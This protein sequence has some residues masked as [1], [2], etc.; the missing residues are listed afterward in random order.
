MIDGRNVDRQGA[1]K[2]SKMRSWSA[3]TL[4]LSLT[5]PSTGQSYGQSPGPATGGAVVPAKTVSPGSGEQQPI[6]FKTSEVSLDIVVTDKK[7][8]PVRDIRTEELEIY[9]DGARQ[10][11]T[12]FR[13]ISDSPDSKGSDKNEAA[14][15]RSESSNAKPL[16]LVT[17]LF[18]HLSVQRV[19]PVRDAAFQ[20]IDNS[21][22][23]SMQVRVMTI[24]RKLYL[25]ENFTGDKKRLR[26]AVELATSTVEKSHEERS[27]ALA[28]QLRPAAQL[29][30]E[31]ESPRETIR[32]AGD[33][34][35]T[36]T[37]ARMSLDALEQSA[38]MAEEV[39][40][41]HHVFSLIPFA[42][43]H[44]QVPGRKMA[45][46]F[47]DGLYLPPGLAPAIRNAIHESTRGG[48]SFYSINIRDLL[49]GAGNQVS[50][51]ETATVVN[52]TRRTESSAFSTDNANSFNAYRISDRASTNFNTFEYIDRKKELGKKGPL[53]ELTEGTG[54]FLITNTN[55]LNGALKRVAAEMGNYYAVSYLPSRQESDGRFRS[56]S[57][58]IKRDGLVART[59]QGYFAIPASK[60]DRPELSYEGPLLAA[61]NGGLAPHDFPFES[62]AYRF[63]SRGDRTHIAVN[64]AVPRAAMIHEEDKERKAFPVSF[65]ILGLI[66]DEKGEVV[67][68]FSE[69]HELSIA[70]GSIEEARGSSFSLT[71]HFWL[72]TGRYTLETAVEDQR[73]N[74]FST[75]RQ[76]VRIVEPSGRLQTGD[77]LLVRQVDELEAGN[78][79]DADHPLVIG[80]RRI[81]PHLTD[82]FAITELKEISFSLPIYL[83]SGGIATAPSLNI[84]L[85]KDDQVVARNSPDPGQPDATGRIIYTAAIGTDGLKP[86]NY[87]LR[88]TVSQGD[89]RSEEIARFTLTGEMRSDSTPV[90]EEVI[91]S[92]L[93]ASDRVGALTLRALATTHPSTIDV[94]ELLRE[95][96]TSG[97]RMHHEVGEYTYS[98]RKVRRVLNSRGQI[99]SEEYHDYE[100]Y[101][102]NG[103]H[104]LIKFAENGS[105]LA[106]QLIDLNRRVATDLLVKSSAENVPDRQIGYW[107]AS[108]D[109][110]SPR[111]GEKRQWLSLTI[112]PE[113]FFDACEFTAPQTIVLEGRQTMVLDFRPRTSVQLSRDRQWVH[114][115][116]GTLWVDLTDK[117]LIR[118]EGQSKSG[119]DSPVNFVYQQ[120]LLAPGVWAPSLIRVNTA[121]DE[122]LFEGLNWD[123]WFEF[124]NFKKFDTSQIEQKIEA[125]K[126]K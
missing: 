31:A 114:R 40:S 69:P 116:T 90:A 57:V 93:S 115:L 70:P 48:L 97:E 26:Q 12:E 9:E 124:T 76:P 41:P 112:D 3:L 34:T 7:G 30:I 16:H 74:R 120:Q 19:Q 54:G 25:I 101:P 22:S 52:Q 11:V 47:S 78:S 104:A 35:G 105:R 29:K 14:A 92:S 77:L 73:T 17:M 126:E 98:L 2:V 1:G 39:K 43:S 96:R 10:L 61:L 121:G 5:L 15:G 63:E 37:L 80:N 84:E 75:D 109:G 45:I 89:E 68:Q 83:Q 20:F 65:S 91:A 55:D 6:R 79:A 118:I 51:L 13:P 23:D 60:R 100:A 46:Y 8:R 94:D 99:K 85:L 64:A 18:D 28:A 62:A 36:A 82:H 111:R 42:R 38:R 32:E 44:R 50:R 24:G 59:R 33:S 49:V 72:P 81:V 95:V 58:R 67:Q 53:S 108:L 113:V 125:P 117:S 110:I 56:I 87:L 103:R 71:R 123:A 119:P 106:L 21:V 86:G 4:T 107:G 27:Q 88:A 122:S 66:R 102:A